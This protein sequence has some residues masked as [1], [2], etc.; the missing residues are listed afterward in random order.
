[1][2]NPVLDRDAQTIDPVRTA[3]D[4]QA[5]SE[6]TRDI[7]GNY[8]RYFGSE[9]QS[10]YAPAAQSSTYLDA[11]ARPAAND[12][13][14]SAAKRLADYVPVKVGMKKVQRMGDIPSYPEPAVVDYAPVTEAPVREE[15]KTETRRPQLFETLY[16]KDGQLMDTAAP[17]YV[18]EVMPEYAPAYAPAQAPAP[19]QTPVY[20]P[21]MIPSEED[22]MPS[23]R[24]METLRQR[25][26]QQEQT[27]FF[28]SLS[29]K[30]KIALAVVASVIVLM[31][32]LVCINTVILSSLQAE[33]SFKEAEVQQLSEEA[34]QIRDEISEIT[35][36][37][38]IA[39][40]AQQQGMTRVTD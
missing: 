24:T 30:T 2:A 25:H 39:E 13:I 6:H 26:E 31:I 35:D 9:G 21:S 28:T 23:T 17:A 38:N 40:W 1:M 36:P 16:Y 5:E 32:A 27:G 3:A 7:P 8:Q 12:G 20:D 19:M 37:E 29:A 10:S 15:T 22:A 34:Q 4:L 11:P 18:P 33:I 14:P